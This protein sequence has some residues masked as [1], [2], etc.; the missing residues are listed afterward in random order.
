M[1]SASSAQLWF[2]GPLLCSN[3]VVFPSCKGANSV[4]ATVTFKPKLSLWPVYN[5]VALAS[6]VA[7]G[8]ATKAVRPVACCGPVKYAACLSVLRLWPISNNGQRTVTPKLFL[9]LHREHD[10]YVPRHVDLRP[11]PLSAALL[12]VRDFEY[13]FSLSGPVQKKIRGSKK[14]RNFRPLV[15]WPTKPTAA[16]PGP[17]TGPIDA[18]NLCLASR[19]TPRS[20]RPCQ[21]HDLNPKP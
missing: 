15:T 12:L 7:E 18:L 11:T 20:D 14:V 13:L 3:K 9:D 6:P 2:S 5:R 21:G 16:R 8:R 19:V 10:Y 1:P 4:K 17:L